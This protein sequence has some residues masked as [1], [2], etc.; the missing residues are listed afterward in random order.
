MAN[1]AK[2]NR[3]NFNF[4]ENLL[5]HCVHDSRE[6]PPESG[7][8]FRI[9]KSD[10]DDEICLIFHIDREK[11]PLITS[12]IPRPDYLIF[13]VKGNLC[14]FTIIEMKGKAEKNL[15]HGIE[16]ITTLRDILT[17]EIRHHLPS[18]FKFKLQGILLTPFNS[19][20]PAADIKKESNKGFTILPIQYSHKAELFGCV[21]KLNEITDKYNPSIQSKDSE[22][23]FI[24]NLL[25]KK[26][27]TKRK[28]DKF[29]ADNFI[30]AKE[31]EGVYLN[32][33]FENDEYLAMCANRTKMTLAIKE[34]GKSNEDALEE[35]LENI[36][37]SLSN[38]F[39][40]K[41]IEGQAKKTE[42]QN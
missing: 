25:A 15:R 8:K 42:E 37:I 27:L 38:N 35:C 9:S 21:S 39:Q 2:I 18:R 13:Y 28:N 23:N 20:I 26:V 36:G 29:F 19:E 24:E 41:K 14:I 16:Q 5:I 34:S 6:V 17:T 31:R 7:V 33:E 32:Y 3:D 22:F 11:D 30:Q 4:L 12:E 40:I 1:K 10:K